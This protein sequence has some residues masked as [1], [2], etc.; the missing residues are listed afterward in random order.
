MTLS[1]RGGLIQFHCIYQIRVAGGI[2]PPRSWQ[3]R[4]RQPPWAKQLRYIAAQPNQQQHDGNEPKQTYDCLPNAPEACLQS[5]FIIQIDKPFHSNI[6]FEGRFFRSI[7]LGPAQEYIEAAIQAVEEELASE[8][9][10]NSET[11]MIWPCNKIKVQA[12]RQPTQSAHEIW[13]MV[14]HFLYSKKATPCR[15]SQ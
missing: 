4:N 10:I 12:E 7:W 11:F 13:H 3:D 14:K 5:K 6:P 15:N 8:S 2:D 1:G 9:A